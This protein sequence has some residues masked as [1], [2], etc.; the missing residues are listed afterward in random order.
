[1]ARPIAKDHDDKRRKILSKAAKVFASKG[2]DRASVAQVADACGVSKANLY[3]YYSSKDDILFDILDSYLSGL[4]DRVCGLDVARQSPRDALKMT[5]REILLSYDGSDN[6]HRLQTAG[7]G[8]LSAKHQSILRGY[9]IDLVRHLDGLLLAYEP[10]V[11]AEDSA[12]LRATTMSIF[13]MLNWFYMWKSEA[14][15]AA[16]EEYADLVCCLTLDGVK[17]L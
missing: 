15:E 13:G 1:M 6:E 5:V 3:H 9:Q 11:F 7:L 14:D 2:F 12:K 16:R 4:R 8:H 10:E 17:G